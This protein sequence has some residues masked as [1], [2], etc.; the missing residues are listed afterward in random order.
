MYIYVPCNAMTSHEGRIRCLET[1][2]LA[3][4]YMKSLSYA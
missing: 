1:G 4:G 3:K 2:K